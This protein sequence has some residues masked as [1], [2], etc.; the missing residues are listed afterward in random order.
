MYCDFQTAETQIFIGGSKQEYV[1]ALVD[2]SGNEQDLSEATVTFLLADYS[3]NSVNVIKKEAYT[4]GNI[5]VVTLESD[6]TKGLCGRY[7]FQLEVALTE[8]DRFIPIKG[9]INIIG[10]NGESRGGQEYVE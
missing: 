2:A 1:F 6:E 3:D 10:K 9:E 8:T 5:A 4:E 7:N